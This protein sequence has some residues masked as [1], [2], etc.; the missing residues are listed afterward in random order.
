[1]K[2]LMP[3]LGLASLALVLAVSAQ[4]GVS[5][6]FA[7]CD[8]L[9]KPKRSDDGMRGEATIASWGGWPGQNPGAQPVTVINA[10][11]RALDS[12]KLLDEQTL[13]RAHMMRARGAAQ[14]QLAEYAKALADFEAARAA[15]REY[16]GDFFYERSMGVSLDLLRAIALNDL[17]RREEAL[18]LSDAALAKRPYALAVQRVATFLRAGNGDAPTDPALWQTLAQIDPATRSLTSQLAGTPDDFRMLAA[19]SGEPVVEMPPPPTLEELMRGGGGAEAFAGKWLAATGKVM[20]TA[21]AHAATG[22]ADTARRWVEA[23][24]A[25]LSTEAKGDEAKPGG[26]DTLVRKLSMVGA[27]DPYA[28]MV[29]A[30]IVV[31]EGRFADAAAALDGKNFKHSPVTDDLW[32]AYAAATADGDAPALPALGDAPER[33]SPKLAALAPDLLMR[34]ESERKLIDYKKSRPNVLAALAGAAVT[35]GVG[36]L[37]GIP[38]TSGFEQT[39]L[40]DGTVKVEYTGNTTSGA[41]VQEM[42][43]LRAAEIAQEAGKTHFHIAGRED[44]QRYLTQSQY[45]V[46]RSRTLTGYKTVMTIALLDDG[47][48][49]SAQAVDALAVIDA[50]GPIYYGE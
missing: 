29:E 49:N 37:N 7:G 1:M 38:R 43:L 45:G 48:A 6:D 24:R 36:L 16:D 27:F 42:T 17:G 3:G 39:E 9:R 26:L 35:M 32:D 11:N 25:A 33:T 23:T 50:L 10:C 44:Y 41:I 12:G 5:E 18:A 19:T 22:D 30:R 2:N 46:E 47:G 13:R 4:A 28:A 21:Y 34:P 15:G 40:P 8:G 14:L 31:N 20:R